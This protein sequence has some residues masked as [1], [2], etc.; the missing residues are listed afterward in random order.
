MKMNR[1][2]RSKQK[3]MAFGI[4]KTKLFHSLEDQAVN[5]KSTV[6]IKPIYKFLHGRFRKVQQKTDHFTFI[7]I[8]ANIGSIIL[9]VIKLLS[10]SITIGEEMCSF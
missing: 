7:Q 9:V 6:L 10:I 3:L 4:E 5:E 8:K 1:M 2:F